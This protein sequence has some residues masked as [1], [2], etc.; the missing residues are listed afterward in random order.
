[1]R[2][3]IYARE[4]RAGAIP[5]LAHSLRVKEDMAGKIYDSARSAM[6]IDGTITDEAQK[7]VIQ[8]P[9]S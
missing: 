8:I 3:L 6:T 9:S 2:G 4:N 5:V 7:R 1:M